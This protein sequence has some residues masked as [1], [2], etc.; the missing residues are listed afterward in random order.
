MKHCQNMVELHTVFLEFSDNLNKR[1]GY[2]TSK[3]TIL[4]IWSIL[5]LKMC[6]LVKDKQEFFFFF[7]N[8]HIHIP[9]V[10]YYSFAFSDLS[11]DQHDWT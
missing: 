3:Q 8:S 10:H 11:T 4:H 1:N 6:L 9:E 2:F 7:C 5:T